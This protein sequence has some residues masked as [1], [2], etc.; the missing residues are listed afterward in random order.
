MTIFSGEQLLFVTSNQ[1]EGVVGAG[2]KDKNGKN[3]R[4]GTVR[5]DIEESRDVSTNLASHAI[6]S[7]HHE[8]RNDPQNGAS[9]RDQQEENHDEHSRQEKC[10]VRAGKNPS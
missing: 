1:Q 9:I 8:Q 2:S 10:E 5:G 7:S 6:R 3:S 4:D